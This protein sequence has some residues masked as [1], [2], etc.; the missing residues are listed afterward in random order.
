MAKKNQQ[1]TIEIED[2]DIIDLSAS[3]AEQSLRKQK[4]SFDFSRIQ[5]I[6]DLIED[7]DEGELLVKALFYGDF[8]KGKTTLGATFPK[9]MLIID[10]NERGTDSVRGEYERGDVKRF[11][12]T[13]WEQ[14][15]DIYWYLQTAKHPFKSVMI[16]TLT[17]L[18]DLTLKYVMQKDSDIDAS[19][20][21]EMPHQ[22]HY[23]MSGQI[24]REWILKYRNL[25][26]NVVF[27]CQEKRKKDEDAIV[28][29][30]PQVGPELSPSVLR[31]AGAAVGI[32]G[33]CFVREV[34]GEDG[35]TKTHF[36]L[37]VGPSSQYRTK[38]RV[39]KS[40]S[41]VVPKVIYDPSYDKLVAVMK[42][43]YKKPTKKKARS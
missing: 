25:P 5:A 40:Q 1:T 4:D 32:I 29:E 7:V 23:G 9:P 15:V 36:G 10:V 24:M 43:E 35:K 31:T 38:I 34:D 11:K 30:E 20:D 27:N 17:Q 42:G 13:E 16:D 39:P 41:A 21:L 12:V 28:D 37:R 14:I 6:G 19:V 33:H 26:M 22:R 3:P 2:D 18:N 8:G